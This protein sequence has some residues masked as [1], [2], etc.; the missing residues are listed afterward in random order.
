MFNSFHKALCKADFIK[1]DNFDEL[2][3]PA[4]LEIK[5]GA[6]ECY[7]TFR[8]CNSHLKIWRYTEKPIRNTQK[9]KCLSQEMCENHGVYSALCLVRFKQFLN[10]KFTPLSIYGSCLPLQTIRCHRPARWR[11][12]PRHAS[13]IASVRKWPCDGLPLREGGMKGKVDSESTVSSLQCNTHGNEKKCRRISTLPAAKQVQARPTRRRIVM[14]HLTADLW[15]I[16]CHV[17]PMTLHAQNKNIP[18]VIFLWAVSIS[19]IGGRSSES[20]YII[21]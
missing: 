17:N 10:Q 11:Y 12:P 14:M 18:L 15:C 9:C 2:L 19:K 1:W 7:H 20:S 8:C 21:F 3:I 16:H 4:T 6:V 13:S 5:E